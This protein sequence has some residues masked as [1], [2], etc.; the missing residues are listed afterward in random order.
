M[1]ACYW[2]GDS[3]AYNLKQKF[4]E[5]GFSL[6][7]KSKIIWWQRAETQ[8]KVGPGRPA[9]SL[10]ARAGPLLPPLSAGS[11]S[12]TALTTPAATRKGQGKYSHVS[13]PSSL[14]DVDWELLVL[15]Q[16]MKLCTAPAKAG[17]AGFS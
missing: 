3:S 4:K 5:Q 10:Q 6:L 2:C 8:G 15:L 11:S 12:C 17:G 9:R 16:A 7:G 13:A 14:G 1:V